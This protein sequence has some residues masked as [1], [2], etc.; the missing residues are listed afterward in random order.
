MEFADGWVRFSNKNAK[1]P[2][3]PTVRE[4]WKFCN[5][6]KIGTRRS[7]LSHRLSYPFK[8]NLN[9]RFDLLLYKTALS[10]NQMHDFSFDSN[11]V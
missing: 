3:L 4:Q 1:T 7:I 6:N 11:H 10:G 5:N 8:L 2:V 9:F